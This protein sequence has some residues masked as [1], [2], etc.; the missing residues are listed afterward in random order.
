VETGESPNR[1]R[2]IRESKRMSGRELADLLDTTSQQIYRL[3]MGERRLTDEWMTKLAKA[4]GCHPFDILSVQL[5]KNTAKV[6]A[7]VAI[8]CRLLPYENPDTIELPSQLEGLTAV[9]VKDEA[10]WPR[11]E[12]GDVLLYTRPVG[13]EWRPEDCLG[14][15]CVVET[16]VGSMFIKRVLPGSTPDSYRLTSFRD[17]AVEN[18]KIKWA[19]TITWVMRHRRA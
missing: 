19:A 7:F 10:L 16:A 18:V 8:D 9:Q 1:I 5:K 13:D 6:S 11:Y 14:R 2:E 4:L 12:P 15:E 3:E 17:N